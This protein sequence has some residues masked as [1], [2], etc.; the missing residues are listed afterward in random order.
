MKP[1]RTQL[2]SAVLAVLGVAL[3][4]VLGIG[5]A[6]GRADTLP[7]EQVIAKAA[8]PSAQVDPGRQPEVL[9]LRVYFR[10]RFERDRL[11]TELGAAEVATS[12]GFLTLWTDRATYN[13]LRARGLQVEIDADTTRQANNPH[14][15]GA[16]SP[17]TFYGGYR[18]VEEMQTFLDAKVAAYPTLAAK[19]DTGD[20]WCKTHPGGCTL[21]APPWNGYDLW[22]LRITNQAIPGP[23]PVFWLDAGIHSRELATPE[24]AMRFIDWLLNNYNSDADARWLV[25]YQDIWV[26]PMLNPDGHHMV[27][28]GGG[29]PYTQRKNGDRDDGCVVFPPLGGNQLGTDINRNFP[30]LWA[31]CGGSSG[32]NCNE[33]YRGPAAGSEEETQAVMAKIRALIADQRGPNNTDPA[34]L[35]TTGIIQSM[36]SYANLNLYPWGWTTTAAPNSTDLG[37]IAR[38]MSATNAG[39]PG[40]NYQACQPP[41]CLYGVDGDSFDWSYGELGA[42]SYTT[43]LEGGTFF[44]AYSTIDSTIWPNNRGMLIYMAKIARTPYL[45]ARGPDTNNVAGSPLTVTQGL[46][47]QL[48]ASINYAWT[49]N[50]YTQNVAAAEYYL[51]TPPWAGGTA[52]AMTATDGSFN[53]PTEAVQATIN[54]GTLA[55]GRHIVFVRGRGVNSYGGFPSWGP[56]AAVFLTVTNPNVLVGHLIW[57][58][59]PAQPHPLNQL[60]LTLTLRLGAS[61][62]TYPN[63]TTDAGGVFTVPVSTLPNGVYTWWVKGPQYLASSGPVS[64]SGAP[65][66]QQ[67]MDQQRAGDV[68]NSNLV[69]I[70]DFTLLRATFGKACGDPGYDGRADFTGDCLVDITDFTLQRS[71]FGQG[72][73]PPTNPG[74]ALVV[75]ARYSFCPARLGIL[76]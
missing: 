18:T 57:Q 25:D 3:G 23:K 13:A 49:G 67:E 24:V 66:T 41:N 64:L 26:M 30:F 10:D 27:E 19:V 2:L 37:N 39:P 59:R 52:V 60:P 20:S 22:A 31:C 36:H 53:S 15:F 76:P 48:S 9:V 44:P 68:D 45:L 65:V 42:A 6:T 43:E 74:A 75:A 56:V 61:V 73:P 32:S 4:V 7:G 40:N 12:G 34:P 69:D 17:D 63:Q 5:A 62:I 38:H 28:A 46:T 71:N 70:T 72:G 47:V 58:G 16:D 29:S 14:L 55:V 51:D 35:T 50:S 8:N 54:T 21:P 33:T 11:A 1:H